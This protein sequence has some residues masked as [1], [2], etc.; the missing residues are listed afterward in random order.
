MLLMN[1]T[2]PYY[3]PQRSWG[4]V[5]VSEACVK[6][7]VHR[8]GMR[9]WHAWQWGM[10]GGGHTWQGAMCGGLHEWGHA[11][12]GHVWWGH[13]WQGVC[14]T[15]SCV[16]EGMHGSRH[17]HGMGVCMAGGHAWQILRDTVNERAVRIPLECILGLNFFER[18]FED[19]HFLERC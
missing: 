3:R 11:W 12:W 9:G 13:A 16:A 14:M 1:F 8:G 15:G 17:M 6:N 18:I 5:I 19:S 2:A 10:H 7:S 4:K